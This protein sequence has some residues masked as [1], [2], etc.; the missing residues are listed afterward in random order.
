MF[1]YWQSICVGEDISLTP[2]TMLDPPSGLP[3]GAEGTL[4][5]LPLT[6]VRRF[7]L[8][9]GRYDF[10]VVGTSTIGTLAEFLNVQVLALIEPPLYT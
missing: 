6:I 8:A 5:Q 9:P 2:P 1:P 7:V 10:Y 3:G 4:Q